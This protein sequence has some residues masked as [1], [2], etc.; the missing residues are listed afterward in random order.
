MSR[1]DFL[2]WV[3]KGGIL[4]TLSG[5]LFPALAYLWP[6][7][8]HGPK[9]DME[10][11]AALDEIPVGGF[12]KVFLGGSALLLIRTA[13]EIKAFSA[14]CTHLGCVVD[15]D[16]PKREIVCPCHA[17]VFDLEGRVV[18]GPPPRPLPTYPVKVINGKVFIKL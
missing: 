12:K 7:M 3:I 5:M 2:D 10:E 8:G 11:V 4:A 14:I 9:V 6:V 15:W 1:R 13:Q 17:G 18:S 16:G